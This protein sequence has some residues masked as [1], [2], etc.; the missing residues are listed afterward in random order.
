MQSNISSS[1]GMPFSAK[2]SLNRVT[3]TLVALLVFLEFLCYMTSLIS[4]S[5]EVPKCAEFGLNLLLMFWMVSASATCDAIFTFKANGKAVQDV[6]ALQW[7]SGEYI[8]W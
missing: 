6:A 1:I 5:V 2:Y 8:V 7:C 4:S 3:D